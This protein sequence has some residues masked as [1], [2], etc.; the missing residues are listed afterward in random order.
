MAAV[1]WLQEQ[2]D[3]QPEAVKSIRVFTFHEAWRLAVKQP[4]TTEEAQYSLPFSV[5]AALVHSRLGPV[6]MTGAGLLDPRVL[7]L[8]DLIEV[9]E[10]PL[11]SARFP[12]E[13]YA[14]VQI[15]TTH[16]KRF[17]S[18]EFQAPWGETDLPGDEVLLDKFRW[19]AHTRLSDQR[20]AELEALI[21][22]CPELPDVQP[23]NAALAEP[24]DLL[25]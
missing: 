2:Y 14:R 25:S 22:G 3:I 6:E 1:Q 21:W 10:D 18:G 20:T 17:A 5:A 15:K 19:L 24:S 8:L 11:L 9:L 12:A 13:R 23:L 16:G 4:Q 7:R